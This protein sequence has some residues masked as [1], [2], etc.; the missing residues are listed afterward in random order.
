MSSV[1]YINHNVINTLEGVVAHGCNCQG[2]MGSGVALAIRKRWLYAYQRYQEMVTSHRE[3]HHPDMSGLL[4]LSLIVN[5]GDDLLTP[6]NSLFVAN[7]FTQNYYG[8]DGRK[9]ADIAAI[10]VALSSTM[11]FCRGAN[12]PL[13]MPRIGCG[14]GGLSWDEEVGPIVEQLQRTHNVQVY[15]CDL[16]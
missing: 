6:I 15:V 11:S 10:E 5:V 9:Y 1:E 4:G 16:I 14:L 7:M 13:Y 3:K 12:L 2:V 8:N